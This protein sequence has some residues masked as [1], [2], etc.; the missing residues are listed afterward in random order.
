MINKYILNYNNKINE[1]K[2]VHEYK[3]N[4]SF[5]G[6]YLLLIYI[7]FNNMMVILERII[8]KRILEVKG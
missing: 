8:Q 4:I 6:R 2:R 1:A 3:C 7:P 5:K